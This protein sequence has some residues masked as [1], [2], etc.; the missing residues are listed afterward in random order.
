M[1]EIDPLDF[2]EVD[3]VK[4]YNT[5]LVLCILLISM[6]GLILSMLYQ[7]VLLQ[8]KKTAYHIPDVRTDE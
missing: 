3:S 8:K 1:A 5:L 7:Y 2:Q 6:S 4:F